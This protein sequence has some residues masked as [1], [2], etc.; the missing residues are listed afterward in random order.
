MRWG[1]LNIKHPKFNEEKTIIDEKINLKDLEKIQ[2]V[3]FD[4]QYKVKFF[5]NLVKMTNQNGAVNT[6]T[7]NIYNNHCGNL[8]NDVYIVK[9][10]L[11]TLTVI[12]LVTILANFAYKLHD[13]N[14]RKMK[15]RYALRRSHVILN[16]NKQSEEN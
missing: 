3:N 9:I 11:I 16:E 12:V 15:K 5:E 7:E 10:L 2:T 4:E 6:N 1:W 13:I 8:Q 14:R